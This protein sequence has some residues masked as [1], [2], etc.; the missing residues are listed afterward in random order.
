MGRDLQKIYHFAEEKRQQ[1]V[2][3][4]G[5]LLEP[6]SFDQLLLLKT[7][8]ADKIFAGQT[9]DTTPKIY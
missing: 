6:G 5:N 7:K 4:H 8:V 3:L 2:F 9:S 1:H